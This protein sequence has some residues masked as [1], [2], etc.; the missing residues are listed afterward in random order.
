MGNWRLGRKKFAAAKRTLAALWPVGVTLAA[1]GGCA[2]HHASRP[3]APPPPAVTVALPAQQ[4][5][6]EWDEYTGRL[7]AVES[8][9]V[10][11]RVSGLVVATPFEEGAVVQKGD[12]LVELDVRPFQA[13][14]DSKLAAQAQA[15]AQADLAQITYAH[16]KSMRAEA[17]ASIIEFQEAEAT[18]RAAQAALA[19]AQA[20]V[21][22][23][24]LN[25]EWC[26]VTAPIAGR[27]SRKAVTLGNMVTGGTGTGTLLTTITSID[28]IYCYLDVDERSILKYQR[29]AQEKKRMDA[30]A[31]GVPCQMQLAN[32]SGYPHEGVIDFVDNRV[33]PDTGSMW[34]RGVFPNPDGLLT[35]GFFGRVRIPGS[36]RY[37]TLLVPD[38]AVTA[39]QSE[40]EVLVVTTDDVVQARTVRLGRL[41]GEL[42]SIVSGIGPDDRVVI[43]GLMRARPGM[44]VVVQESEIPVAMLRPKV[45]GLT[46]TD[47]LAAASPGNT[48]EADDPPA[49]AALNG[50]PGEPTPGPLDAHAMRRDTP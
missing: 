11:A 32:E 4:D 47:A 23:A 12:V 10:R 50:S 28:P 13:D 17:S 5:V 41:F 6:V 18:L 3:P 42:R 43:N 20:N 46:A 21:E 25:V 22:A 40:K 1:V 45:L 7:E 30:R 14:L 34:L 31:R 24:R 8:A 48:A 2:P 33:N 38:V 27:I 19:G 44:K 35:P 9:D 29:L 39:D 26:R 36:E 15:A 16:T 37:T 49:A